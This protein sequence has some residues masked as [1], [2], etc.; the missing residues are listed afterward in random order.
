MPDFHIASSWAV[1]ESSRGFR[2]LRKLAA[3][4]LIAVLMSAANALSQCGHTV[5]GHSG[6]IVTPTAEIMPDG[7]IAANISRIP[8]LYADNYK[9][10]DRTTY[11]ASMGFLPFL[12]AS[13]GFIRPDNFQGGIGDR[14]VSLRLRLLRESGSRPAV[15]VGMQDFFAVEDLGLEPPAAQHFTS[16]YIVMTKHVPS[17]WGTTLGINVGYGLNYLPSYDKQLTGLFWGLLFS[18]IKP[19]QMIYEYDSEYT[20][21]G[22]RFFFFQRVHYMLSF[23]KL[24]YMM[25][26]LSFTINLSKK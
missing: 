4:T 15:A 23:W 12:E 21:A 1:F 25:H 18:P 8:K 7:Q 19:V 20:N 10:Y 26:Q 17:F 13:I 5:L 3:A 6:F 22:L 2:M 16:S 14:T 11:I 24:K 9:P